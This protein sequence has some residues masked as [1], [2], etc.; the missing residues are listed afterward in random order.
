M[1]VQCAPRRPRVEIAEPQTS[2]AL[3]QDWSNGLV[4][5]LC[6]LIVNE[7]KVASKL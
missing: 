3:P 6:E 5:L 1:A 7:Q 2:G 4:Q